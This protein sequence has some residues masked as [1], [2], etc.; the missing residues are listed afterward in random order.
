MPK[1][2]NI[3][4][5]LAWIW[6]IDLRSD[7]PTLRREA[8]GGFSLTEVLV[9]I[10]V[11]AVLTALA[12]PAFSS[13]VS[14]YRLKAATREVYSKFQLAK[15]TAVNRNSD[16]TVCFNQ[17]LGTQACD[18]LVF[19]DS[20]NDL[21]YDSGEQVLTCRRWASYNGV[22]YDLSQ[23]GGD[24]LSFMENDDAHPAIA[25]KPNGLPVNNLG[26]LGMGT[27]FLKN[28][29]DRKTKVIVSSA[30]HIRIE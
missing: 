10:L 12:I 30:G 4:C 22:Q 1:I 15:Q 16:C 14:D 6:R 2:K 5:A 13:W 21:E 29:N 3:P 8:M 23:G 24:G 27:V 17:N 19:V 9:V 26:G 25:F 20:D 18:Y 11:L 28:A 7:G